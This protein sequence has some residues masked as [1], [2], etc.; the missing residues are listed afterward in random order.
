VVDV[1]EDGRL[2]YRPSRFTRAPPAI[3]RAPAAIAS[4][5]C[6]STMPSCASLAMAP[7][8]TVYGFWSSVPRRMSAT[9]ATAFATNSSYT[10]AST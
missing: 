5:T 2:K 10:G 6:R 9:T 3:A 4:S 1:G 7:T 8:S